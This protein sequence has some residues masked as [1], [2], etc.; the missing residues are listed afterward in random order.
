VVLGGGVAFGE[1][2]LVVGKVVAG[3]RAWVQLDETFVKIGGV[4]GAECLGTGSGDNVLV[5][6]GFPGVEMPPEEDGYQGK[7]GE[8]RYDLQ[9]GLHG[10]LL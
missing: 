7:A 1:E 9:K 2:T 6:L 8:G 10:E 5:A 3:E 4:L